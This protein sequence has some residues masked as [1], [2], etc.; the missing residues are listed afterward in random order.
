MP[1]SIL[2]VL[3]W[4]VVASARFSWEKPSK[5]QSGGTGKFL[6]PARLVGHGVA[7]PADAPGWQVT[8]EGDGRHDERAFAE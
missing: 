2:M 1:D 8:A 5:S 7:H 6:I 3:R 4:L